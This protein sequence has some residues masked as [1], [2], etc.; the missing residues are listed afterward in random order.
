MC[1]QP[2]FLGKAAILV[3]TTELSGAEET[4][5]YMAFPPFTWGFRM[6]GSLDVVYRS[7]K[8]A[9]QYRNAVE[10]KISEL[11][12]EFSE[13][14]TTPRPSPTLK[15]LMFFNIMKSK[16]TLHRNILPHDYEFWKEKGWLDRDFYH[17][18]GF[19]RLKSK[20]AKILAGRRARTII[21]KYGLS[22]L[23]DTPANDPSRNHT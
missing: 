23:L 11:A 2:H 5:D 16:V 13:A 9:G 14:L 22:H 17:Q 8:Q 15:E 10:K 18:D 12:H 6:A 21:D 1:H 4:L 19:P 3:V 7:F 20:L